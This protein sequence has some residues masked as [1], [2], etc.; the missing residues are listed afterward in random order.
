M[1][2]QLN[3][4]QFLQTTMGVSLGAVLASR[5][6]GIAV[7]ADRTR[8][9][10]ERLFESDNPTLVRLAVDV[11]RNCVLAKIKPPEGTAKRRWLQAGTGD[12]FYG[13]WIWDTMFVVDLLAI[14]P[15]HKETIRDV[16]QNYWDFQERWNA[17]FPAYAHNMVSCM[18]EPRGNVKPW[19]EYPAYSQIPILGWG[20]ERVYQRNGDKELLRQ[21][22]VPLEKFHEWYWRER[23]VTDSGLIAVG[24]YSDNVQEARNETYDNE[25]CLDDLMLTLHPKRQDVP[26]WPWGG[27]GRWYGNICVPGNTGY[28]LLAERSLARL[29]TILGDKAMAKRRKKRI[30]K[31][32][33]AV[34]RHMWD[35]ESGTFLAVNRDTFEKIRVATI[36]S[37]MPLVAEVPTP[38]MVKRMAEA[39]QTDHW[40]TPLPIP[41]VDRH[42]KR[43]VSN[44]YW[45]GDVWPVPNY[46]V[47]C[48]FAAAGHRAIAVEIAD[49][50]VANAITNGINEHY[51]SVTG[52]PLG[53]G[54]LGMS[55]SIITLMLDGLTSKYHLKVRKTA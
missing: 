21:S 35:K 19:Y 16:F 10:L 39:I 28:L 50:T 6:I 30:D 43:W 20:I 49:K 54:N 7:A 3:R 55:C 47:A 12:A 33:A 36:G 34:R 18:I 32:I 38:N 48:G 41:T 13:Q 22:L 11:M 25:C 2:T 15:E 17:R 45:R 9:E 24:T 14:L 46:Q 44:S 5:A 26:P 29:A 4:R 37:W 31:A 52:K 8:E 1:R 53:V 40:Q 51:D 42:D 27:E 23:D